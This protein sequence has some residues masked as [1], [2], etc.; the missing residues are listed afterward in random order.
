MLGAIIGDIAGSIYEFNNYRRTDFEFMSEDCTYTDDSVMTAAVAQAILDWRNGAPDL[1]FETV[2]RMREFG[3]ADPG[4]GY[5]GM[6][7][8]WLASEQPMGP[9]GSY[10]NGSAMR[11]S[12]AGFAAGSVE[13]AKL[14][15]REVTRVTHDHP[16]GLKG[17]EA[18]AVLIRL[19]LEGKT[20]AE[21][22]AYAEE[23]YYPLDFT[24][25]EIRPYYQFNETCQDTVPQ[26][27]EAFLESE[28]F[29]SA[30]RLAVSVGGD[31]DT[32]AAITGGIA[33]AYYGIPQVL[34]ERALGFL[35]VPI[36]AVLG[37]FEAA[38]PPK[39]I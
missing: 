23:H 26:A 1:A 31:S 37:R 14:I 19:A 25:D 5:G 4:R 7:R 9:Y 22:R 27:I 34:R 30:I 32:L 17:A 38:Y 28:D 39:V 3:R 29:E 8:R 11:V 36:L 18:A 13:E 16:E 24:I 20:K 33:E 2:A 21:L 12:A 15:S 35:S 6:F 10:G